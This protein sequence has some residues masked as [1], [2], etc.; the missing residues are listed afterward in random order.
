M[1]VAPPPSDGLLGPDK[2]GVAVHFTWPL[3][4][5]KMPPS[6]TPSPTRGVGVN[7]ADGTRPIKRQP[8]QCLVIRYRFQ[9]N[10]QRYQ[11]PAVSQ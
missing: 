2:H 8:G 7:K 4:P 6:P 1:A 5:K 3:M 11:P 9:Q 10:Q